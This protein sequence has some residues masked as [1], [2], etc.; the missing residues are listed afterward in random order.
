[1]GA[2]QLT[3][4]GAITDAFISKL[5]ASGSALAYSTYL[6]GSN[7]DSGSSIAVD[8]LGNAYIT[9][10]TDSLNFPTTPSAFQTTIGGGSY[11]DAF[12]T[13]LSL[14]TSIPVGPVTTASLNGPSGN[15]GWYLGAVTV[16]LSATDPNSPVSA[17]YYRVDSGP[18]QG[19]GAP[20]PISSDGVHQLLFYSVDIA[21]Q[22]ETPHG[23][24]IE[25]DST[26]PTSRVAALPAT[27]PSPNF[28]VQWSG[29][30]ALSGMRDVTVYVSDNG[31]PFTVLLL[32]TT[33]SQ[34]AFG[35]V[36]GHTY[37]FYSIA[38]D[39]AGNQENPKTVAE[40]TTRVAIP[41][42][43]VSTLAALEP[44]ANFVVQWVGTDTGGPGI[45]DFTVYVS[46]NGGPFTRW[47]VQTSAA[48]GTFA[49]VAGHTFGFYSI[50]R[51]MA[52]NQENP[53]TAAEA[54]TQVAA[55]VPGD[56]NGDG[57]VNCL[58]IAIVKASFNKKVGQPGFDPR[59]DVNHDGVVNILDLA[60]VSQKLVP[61]TTCQ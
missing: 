52:G 20:F 17:T 13:K 59:A 24:T 43:R 55:I 12:V 11:F 27:E 60:F 14:G 1:V 42:S 33:A 5:N 29:T 58:D 38:R 37:G 9:G 56:L 4:G 39:A 61:G 10:T 28:N 47:L 34:G 45:H 18:Y 7:N 32:Q 16:T 26:K 54:T 15:N 22:Q 23:T 19:Y 49:G 41:V 48:Q 57:R 21:G 40:T 8:A 53:K 46:D 3:F 30:D 25:I 35:G 6:G 44:V 50:A 31:A 2:L 36:G 51:D